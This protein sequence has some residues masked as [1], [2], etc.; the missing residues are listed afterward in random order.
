M[1][2][3]AN[4]GT[5]TP[6][7]TWVEPCEIPGAPR[8]NSYEPAL[9]Q[10]SLNFT[11]MGARGATK[12]RGTSNHTKRLCGIYTVSYSNRVPDPFLTVITVFGDESRT[13]NR[14]NRGVTRETVSH[15]VK[16]HIRKQ[17]RSYFTPS[18]KPFRKD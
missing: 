2:V 7:Q 5:N 11:G 4:T 1:Y 15:S 13:E 8:P 6:W 14:G 12:V 9:V 17:G 10:T 16:G 3:C 18:T